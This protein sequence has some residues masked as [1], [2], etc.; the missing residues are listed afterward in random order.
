M[1]K[2]KLSKEGKPVGHLIMELEELFDKK[3]DGRQKK[4]IIS[5]KQSLNPKIKEIN[6]LSGFKMYHPIK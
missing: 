1:A 2:Q 5:W 6:I 4:E 3:P